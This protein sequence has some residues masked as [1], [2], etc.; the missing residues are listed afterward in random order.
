MCQICNIVM[1]K[2]YK[3]YEKVTSLLQI[4]MR[5]LRSVSGGSVSGT[6]CPERRGGSQS[7]PQAPRDRPSSKRNLED[8]YEDGEK[9]SPVLAAGVVAIAG[10]QAADLPCQGQTG[11]VREDLHAYGDGFYGHPR[12]RHL[13]LVLGLYPGR[14]RLQRHRCADPELCWCRWRARPHDRQLLDPASW[15]LFDR[16]PGLQTAYGTLPGRSRPTTCRTRT[17]P[18]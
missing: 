17:R 11:S 7:V 18:N 15:Q 16:Y 1:K 10:A 3:S 2:L 14:L 8:Q 5:C 4:F 13:Y 6:V 9:S 12:F